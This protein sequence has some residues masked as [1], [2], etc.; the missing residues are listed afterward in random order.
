MLKI[1]PMI[2]VRPRDRVCLKSELL[3]HELKNQLSRLG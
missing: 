1:N 3:K 2:E